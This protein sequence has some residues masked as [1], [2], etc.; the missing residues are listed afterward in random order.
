M[1]IQG[2][3]IIINEKEVELPYPIYTHLVVNDN[4]LVVLNVPKGH[5]FNENIYCIKSDGSIAWQVK[6]QDYLYKRSSFVNIRQDSLGNVWLVNWDGSQYRVDTSTGE[7][8]E[9][10]FYK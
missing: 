7:I 5:T 6:E 9:K 3:K 1:N 4:I 8:L 10:H 2:N